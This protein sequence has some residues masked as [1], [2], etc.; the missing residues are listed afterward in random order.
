MDGKNTIIM[1]F[2]FDQFIDVAV[3]VVDSVHSLKVKMT[4]R[5]WMLG[6][7]LN[8]LENV[9]D[10]KILVGAFGWSEVTKKIAQL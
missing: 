10:E 7:N 8:L 4:L 5:K 6:S 1:F 3:V 2:E 9:K